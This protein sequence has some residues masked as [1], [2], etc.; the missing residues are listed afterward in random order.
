MQLK[1]LFNQYLIEELLIIQ[2]QYENY[3]F[4]F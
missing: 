3:E 1:N 2:Y 4:I